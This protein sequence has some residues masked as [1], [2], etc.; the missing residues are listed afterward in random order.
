MTTKT[1][2]TT[3]YRHMDRYSIMGK[4]YLVLARTWIHYWR[5]R[6]GTSTT[7]PVGAYR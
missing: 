5:R 1:A 7:W 4:C 2:K 6:L 3:D